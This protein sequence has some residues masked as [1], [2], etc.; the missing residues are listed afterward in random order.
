MLVRS[1]DAAT[2]TGQ[3]VTRRKT[4]RKLGDP[5]AAQ[6][7]VPARRSRPAAKATASEVVPP[8]VAAEP[9]PGR[10]KTTP[11][12]DFANPPLV[13][14]EPL[15]SGK[16]LFDHAWPKSIQPGA[17]DRKTERVLNIGG[18]DYVINAGVLAFYKAHPARRH[19]LAQAIVKANR[20]A[21]K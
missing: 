1:T 13:K 20:P 21:K 2:S 5:A 6:R 16:A 19:E 12:P 3:R 14:Q 9:K 7:P 17:I 8:A 15:P 10:I 18:I 4:D 11:S